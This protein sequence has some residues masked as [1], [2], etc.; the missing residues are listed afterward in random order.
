MSDFPTPIVSLVNNVPMVSSLD[1]AEKFGKN[2]KEVLRAIQNLLGELESDFGQRNF[3]PS[4][5]TNSQNKEQP[6]FNLTRDGFSL[7]AMGFTGKKAL[8]WKVKYIE[9]FNAMEAALSG[10]PQPAPRAS[11]SR[12]PRNTPEYL[13]PLYEIQ[14]RH[15]AGLQGRERDNCTCAMRMRLMRRVGVTSIRRVKPEQVEKAIAVL[16]PP[17]GTWVPY[18]RITHSPEPNNCAP[19]AQKFTCQALEP[20]TSEM[21][22]IMADALDALKRMEGDCDFYMKQIRGNICNTVMSCSTSEEKRRLFCA[23][24]NVHNTAVYALGM[25]KNSLA[26]AWNLGKGV[27]FI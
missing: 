25:A 10:K 26:T 1:V 3:A 15:L 16:T 7:L 9:A 17:I 23:L 22:S 21:T 11:L 24:Q 18:G 6:L 12:I 2:H 5:Y 27:S 13:M 4:S 19:A 8:A 20:D 14:Q